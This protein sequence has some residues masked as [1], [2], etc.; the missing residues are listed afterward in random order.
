MAVKTNAQLAAFFE[1]GDQPSEAEFGHLIDT[2]QPPHVLLLDGDKVLTVEDHAYRLLIMPNISGARTL[3]L[4]TP[5]LDTWFHIVS[6]PLVADGHTLTIKGT[7]NTHFFYG[8]VM[9]HDMN[10]TAQTTALVPGDGTDDDVFTLPTSSGMDLWL[11][12]KSTTVWYIWGWTASTT[13][14]AIANS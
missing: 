13:T 12:A 5:V 4:P 2:V 7:D 8:G 6:L 9:N 14:S 3:T 1:T 11:H 10:Q